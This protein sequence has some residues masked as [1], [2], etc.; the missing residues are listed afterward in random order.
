MKKMIKSATAIFMVLVVCLSTFEF[1]LAL[2]EQISV[3]DF[4]PDVPLANYEDAKV[5]II[6]KEVA[7]TTDKDDLVSL[8]RDDNIVYFKEIMPEEVAT[9]TG[10]PFEFSEDD[11]QD[12]HLGT[13]ITIKGNQYHYIDS[14]KVIAQEDGVI[15]SIP[16]EIE[17]VSNNVDYEEISKGI[18]LS[19][20]VN[21]V[22]TRGLPEGSSES[23][24]K[25]GNVVLRNGTVVGTM[26]YTLYAYKRGTAYVNSVNRKLYDCVA[27]CVFDPK[28]NY[29]C[30][31][32]RVSL[33]RVKNSSA[34]ID[35]TRIASQGTT[36]NVGL[37]L[38]DSPGVNVSWAYASDAF[39]AINNLGSTST[40]SWRIIPVN[41]LLDDT[42]LVQSAVRMYAPIVAPRGNINIVLTVPVLDSNGKVVNT[43][44]LRGIHSSFG[45]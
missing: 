10:I 9:L 13:A 4:S 32:L 39:K 33:G 45:I 38:S 27:S 20:K 19:E 25:D 11:Y 2:G 24:S 1:A 17:N 5:I 15:A 44:N 34:I 42:W 22:G 26:R 43:C 36:A 35:A 30:L 28:P 21:T 40:N 14:V 8:I 37:S 16:S 23:F 31:D 29:R 18:Y 12:I 6:N 3:E 7:R 41:S